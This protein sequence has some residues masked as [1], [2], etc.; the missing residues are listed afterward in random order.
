MNGK[1]YLNFM[2]KKML[3]LSIFLGAALVGYTTGNVIA[4][5]VKIG[6][7]SGTPFIS[8]QDANSTG[9]YEIRLNDGTGQFQIWDMTNSRNALIVAST[10]NVGVGDAASTITDF[11]IGCNDGS[12]SIQTRAFN[13][14]ASNTVK[15]IGPTGVAKFQL[16][17]A[18]TSAGP[19]IFKITTKDDGT[20]CMGDPKGIKCMLIFDLNGTNPGQVKEADGTCIANC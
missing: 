13:G 2:N 8:F 17:D 7:T 3:I 15:A 16:E 5:E 10:G 11:V 14:T 20:I 4:Q 1:K 12:C 6:D 9:M 19:L 18:F